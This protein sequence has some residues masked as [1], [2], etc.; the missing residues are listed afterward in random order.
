[1]LSAGTP[2]A[3]AAEIERRARVEDDVLVDRQLDKYVD[4]GILDPDHPE[5][6]YFKLDLLRYWQASTRKSIYL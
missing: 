6:A 1:M 2:E 4:E 5:W 3:D